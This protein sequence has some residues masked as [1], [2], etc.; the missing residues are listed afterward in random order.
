MVFPRDFLYISVK[1]WAVFY[2]CYFELVE[3]SDRIR[4]A[5]IWPL[6][7]RQQLS[8]KEEDSKP[9][10]VL[11]LGTGRWAWS[12]GRRISTDN[13]R[14]LTTGHSL[15]SSSASGWT[16]SESRDLRLA[17]TSGGDQE[18]KEEDQGSLQ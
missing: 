12:R 16:V 17:V 5:Q 4:K 18:G 13:S 11:S 3:E 15:R 9:W 2:I 14:K 10:E 8:R 1:E 6:V 7:Q